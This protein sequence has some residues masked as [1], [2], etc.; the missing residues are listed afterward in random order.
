MKDW[1]LYCLYFGFGVAVTTGINLWR[2]REVVPP[3]PVQEVEPVKEPNFYD[4]LKSIED[5]HT[6]SWKAKM[7]AL[8]EENKPLLKEK[9]SRGWRSVVR[10]LTSE[11]LCA[12]RN[13]YNSGLCLSGVSTRIF[14]KKDE[15]YVTWYWYRDCEEE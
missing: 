14:R 5:D 7:R 3:P 15:C 1:Q 4:E 12:G 6:D 10:P 11:E 13:F 9:A 8:F 2:N